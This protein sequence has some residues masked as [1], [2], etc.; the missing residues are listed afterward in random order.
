MQLVSTHHYRRILRQA[1]QSVTAIK[2]PRA[3]QHAGPSVSS[4][5][6][7]LAG[8]LAGS[9]LI[10]ASGMTKLVGSRSRAK[11]L[12]PRL[13]KAISIWRT[14]RRR[15][16]F[17]ACTGARHPASEGT[18]SS[19]SVSKGGERV[20]I[21]TC[22]IAFLRWRGLR[23]ITQDTGTGKTKRRRSKLWPE[24]VKA[25]VAV[26]ERRAASAVSRISSVHDSQQPKGMGTLSTSHFAEMETKHVSA[27][28]TRASGPGIF[29]L[30]SGGR[31]GSTLIVRTRFVREL[32]G[33]RGDSQS[34]K[35][36][37]GRVR[38]RRC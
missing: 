12:S 5:A 29:A 17:Q 21:P 25:F 13:F 28:E 31:S 10:L 33:S 1:P 4:F 38:E 7:R 35:E 30:T 9:Y 16:S 3:A 26:V 37:R 14:L 18:S 11:I 8:K 2:F 27:I 6:H 34:G 36:L 20:P 22:R 23:S 32:P 19:R 15:S 24:L